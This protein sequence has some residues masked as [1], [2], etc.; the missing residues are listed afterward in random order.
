MRYKEPSHSVHSGA[1]AARDTALL[2]SRA[3]HSA[4]SLTAARGGSAGGSG[5]L[6]SDL[7]HAAPCDDLC[8]RAASRRLGEEAEAEETAARAPA[9]RQGAGHGLLRGHEGYARSSASGRL[10][11]RHRVE[12]CAPFSLE[13][14]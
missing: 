12:R 7:R 5:C 3:A 10:H 6:W 1:W 13:Q 8:Q 14:I 9:E 2:W 11:P 4:H